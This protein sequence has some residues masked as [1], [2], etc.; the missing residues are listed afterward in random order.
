MKLAK[1]LSALLI[2]LILS[3]TMLPADVFAAPQTDQVRVIVENTTW[4][5]E[6][7]APWDGTLVDTWVDI[8]SSSTMMSAFVDA[9]ATV[10]GTQTGAQSNYVTEVNGLAATD[11]GNMSGWMGS[12]ND[13]FANEGFGSFTVAAGTLH[14]GDEIRI[15]HTMDF[16]E[17]LSS[18][19]ANNDKSVSALL[20]S[21]GSLDKT[22]SKDSLSYTLTLPQGTSSILV[23][24]TASNKNFQVRTYLGTQASG[25]EY[26]RTAAI[27]VQNGSVLTVVCGDP[28][29]PSM[30]NQASGTGETVPATTYTIAVVVS[31]D[32]PQ[33]TIPN[34]K[35][36]VSATAS[37]SVELGQAYSLDLSTIF[38]DADQ[39]ALTYQVSVDGAAAVA[40]SESYSFTPAAAGSHTLVFTAKDAAASSTDTYTVSVSASQGYAKL[41]SLIIHTEFSPSNTNVL[42]KN[43]SDS[44]TQGISFNADT[45]SYT[46]P[47]LTDS[48]T[49]LRFRAAPED[50]DATVTL[51]YNGTTSN[52][53]WASGSS[54]YA[55]CITPGKNT[56]TITVTPPEGSKK[57]PTVYTFT[58]DAFPTLT[59]LTVSAGETN[60]YL[61][62][63]FTAATK[64]YTVTIPQTT[65]EVTV[66][67]SPKGQDYTLTYNGQS[68]NTLNIASAQ[69]VDVVVTAGA[70][71]KALSTTY[72]LSLKKVAQLDFQVNATPSDAIVKVYDHTGALVSA[73]ADGRFSGMFGTYQYTYVV[74]KYGYVAQSGTIPPAGGQ[75]NVTLNKAAD[76]GLTDVNSDWK[77]FRG[78]DSNM[79][80][81]NAPLPIDIQNINLKW[82]KKL[83]SGWSEA[84]S[85][86]I[87]VDQSLVVMAG[88]TLYKLD[89]KTGDIIA[90]GTMAATPDFGY[91]PPTYAQGMIFCPLT[92]GRVQ[93][94]NAKTL[95]SL[96]IYTDPLGGQSLSPITYSDGYIY[97]GFW[98]GET[99]NAN[100]VCLSVTDE[101]VSSKNEAKLPTW[102]HTQPGGFYWAGSVVVGNAVIV[103]TDDGKSGF[104]GASSLYSFNKYTGEVISKLA[105]TGDQR[106]SIAYDKENGKIYFTTKCGYLYRADVSASGVLSGLKGVNHGA[107]TTSTPI[108]YKGKVYFATGS[109]I[110]STGS[111]GNFVVADADTLQML[112]AVA[113]KGYPQCSMLLSTAYEAKTGYIYFYS[114]YNAMPGGIS[115]IKLKPDATS[116][117]DAEL[118]ELYDAAGFQAFCVT[119]LICGPDGTIYYKNDSS[120]I[121]AVGV[122]QAVGVMR[123]IDDIGTV[124]VDSENA[125]LIAR[126]AYN[127]LPEDQKS[128]VTN[129]SALTAAESKLTQLKKQVTDAKAL[130]S[131]IGTVTVDSGNKIADARR[132]Y[133]ALDD[134]QKAL[135][136]N[137]TALAS[138]EK[139]YKTLI[140]QIENVETLIDGIGT[141]TKK[142][143][144]AISAARKAYNALNLAQKKLVGNYDDLKNAEKAYAA[145]FPSGGGDNTGNSG[146]SSSNPSNNP[147]A[148]SSPVKNPTGTG[149]GTTGTTG[150]QKPA[151]DSTSP[152][153]EQPKTDVSQVVEQ[154]GKL[155]AS[156]SQQDIIDALKAYDALSEAD[157]GSVTNLAQLEKA[158]DE[159]ALKNQQDKET[160]ISLPDCPWFVK[161]VVEPVDDK[162]TSASSVGDKLKDNKLLAL[163]DISLLDIRGNTEYTPDGEILVK[164]PLS[165]IPDQKDFD[166]LIAI[167]VGDDGKTEYLETTVEGD[168]LAFQ[169]SSFSYYGIVG[170]HGSSPLELKEESTMPWWP[171]AV[172]GCAGVVVIVALLL[173]R[174]K[175]VYSDR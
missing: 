11:G 51:S 133:D 172:G 121:L 114:T 125:I 139:S 107:Q 143:G 53:T 31:G 55:S 33:N 63:A 18:S 153:T 57:L 42:V 90:T 102:R 175:Q 12:L 10:S 89:L 45:L 70:G 97:T 36:G 79:A 61:D 127:A 130:I 135:V 56:F 17:D 87:I 134:K 39:D 13:W 128:Q 98:N 14:A 73:N 136:T 1:R 2:A 94:F 168:Y 141:V 116:Q 38:E 123:L 122:P 92:G 54:K 30:N 86:Q 165:Q 59:N 155:S 50:A 93:A 104:D 131:A 71:D 28:S 67:A 118:I 151:S 23:T 100:Y 112:Y 132:A 99:K 149:S 66:G 144:S 27:P 96:W 65:T 83:G 106:S 154:I 37:A 8:D 95:E 25:T 140:E 20:F 26:Q 157:K 34:R 146:N 22:F 16:G 160:G 3:V 4:S 43:S 105:I 150:T 137:Y 7:G 109:G 47:A 111:S 9:L 171:W 85:V 78:S 69:K 6:A 40:A 113:L 101:D 169:A 173:S 161:I 81:T 60:F 103:G 147:A 62:K 64:D 91:I 88:T 152:Q 75:V 115:M 84:P 163:W 52:I 119:S 162:D 126:N 35:A 82:N 46:L 166:G 80:I 129:L 76:D 74:S 15:M 145:L 72:S 142:S 148:P 49:Q 117:S 19:W 156:S 32:A 170:Y 44:Y 21:K 68:Q 5:R 174:K 138:A 124:T 110:S 24:P 164:I 167:H 48:V 120:N 29:W 41:K 158:R 58:A 159:M 108:V 77:N